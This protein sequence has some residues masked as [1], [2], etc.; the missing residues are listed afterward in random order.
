MP[1]LRADSLEKYFF[2]RSTTAHVIRA[3]E[4]LLLCGSCRDRLDEFDAFIQAVRD[5]SGNLVTGR[6]E[7]TAG[8]GA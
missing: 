2:Q 8:G 6:Q 5:A 3:E 4:H 7:L 1:H